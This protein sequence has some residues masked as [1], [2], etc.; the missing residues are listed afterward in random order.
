MKVQIRD[1]EALESLTSA[2]LRAYLEARGWTDAG[3]WG[4]RPVV[5]YCKEQDGRKCEVLVPL[6]DTASDYAEFMAEAV[7]TLAD[8]ED[9]S[10]L[11]V[12]NDLAGIGSDAGAHTDHKGNGVTA[13]IELS[14]L[15]RVDLRQE[16]KTE[17]QDFTP[18]LAQT[19]NLAVL[20]ETLNMDLEPVGQ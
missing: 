12:F 11:D 4:E 14:R 15:E 6:R 8:V 5:I 16:W 9:R 7:I 20:S 17:A 3:H 1:R 10:Q 2:T 13:K 19:D 18:W